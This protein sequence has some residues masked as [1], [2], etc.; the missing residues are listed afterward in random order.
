MATWRYLAQN[1]DGTRYEE[2]AAELSGPFFHGSR[3][4]RIRPEAMI[5]PGRQTNN[6]GDVRGRSTH[7]YLTT[8]PQCAASYAKALGG[9]VYEVEPTGALAMDYSGGDYKTTSP[10]RVIRRVPEAELAAQPGRE[11]ELGAG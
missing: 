9:A 1:P 4:S 10:L 3:S 5:T 6:W 8:D 2:R 7:V 11:P